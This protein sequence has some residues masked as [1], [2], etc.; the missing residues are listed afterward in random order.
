[1]SKINRIYVKNIKSISEQEINLNGC[2]AIVTAGNNKGKTTLLNVLPDRL[3]SQ[4]VPVVLKD[5]EETGSAELELTDGDRFIWTLNGNKEKL[6]YIS[7]DNVCTT[8]VREISKRFFPEK[9]DIDKFL[10]KGPKDQ[11]AMLQKLAGLDFSDID[12]RYQKAYEHRTYTNKLLQ[13]STPIV[14]DKEIPDSPVNIDELQKKA[15]DAHLYNS[16]LKSSNEDLRAMQEKIGSLR[17]ELSRLCDEASDLESFVSANEYIDIDKA[18]IKLRESIQLNKV[19]EQNK[20]ALDH[21]IHCEKITKDA[22]DA[23]KEVN[24]IS[25]ERQSLIAKAKFPDGISIVEGDLL[26]DGLP[27]DKKQLSLSKIYITA[28]KLAAMSLGEVKSLYFDASPLDRTSLQEIEKWASDNDLQLL[29][30]KPDF[31]GGEITY[32]IIKE[33]EHE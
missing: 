19:I 32:E 7:K 5:G 27:L 17:K 24:K 25:A 28:L 3:R 6:L 8:S 31:D 11:A 13:N 22:D 1:M 18:N 20:L 23:N 30:E 12:A 15:Y 29:I 9:F 21:N 16:K 2:S 14:V 4:K 10:V 26:V 33:N